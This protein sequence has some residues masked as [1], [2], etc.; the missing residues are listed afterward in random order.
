MRLPRFTSHQLLVAVGVFGIGLVVL[1]TGLKLESM[2]HGDTGAT[3]AQLSTMAGLFLMGFGIGSLTGRLKTAFW[4]G[5]S[6]IAF[7]YIGIYIWMALDY[8]MRVK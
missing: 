2:P 7:F 4:W 1:I 8:W 6:F 3:V 5:L